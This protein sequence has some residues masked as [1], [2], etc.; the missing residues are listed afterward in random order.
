MQSEWAWK[1][2]TASD[3]AGQY[4][5]RD[6]GAEGRVDKLRVVG[7]VESRQTNEKGSKSD[8]KILQVGRTRQGEERPRGPFSL[9]WCDLG[10][11]EIAR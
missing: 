3:N 8:S 10:G 2:R 5:G 9:L 6:R 7:C 1:D 11:L 4:D